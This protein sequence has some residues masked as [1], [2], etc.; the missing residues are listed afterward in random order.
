MASGGSIDLAPLRGRVTGTVL[1]PADAGWDEARRPWNLAI[2]QRPAAVLE[3]S[4]EGC[5]VAAAIEFARERAL[6]VCAQPTG[7]SATWDLAD[8]LLMRTGGLRGVEIDATARVARVEPGARWRDVQGAAGEHGLSGL[9]GTAPNVSVVGYAMGGGV[10]WLGRRYGVAANTIRAVELVTAAGEAVRVDR[11]SEPE[12][13]WALRGGGGNF[14]IVTAMELEL[15]PVERVYAGSLMWPIERAADVLHGWREWVRTLP[16]ETTSIATLLRVPPLPQ[17]PEPMRGRAFVV[18]GACHAGP[19]GEGEEVVRPL[20][21]LATPEMNSFAAMPPAGMG[22]IKNDPEDPTPG[23]SATGLTGD[24]DAEAVDRLLEAAGPDSGTPLLFAE[25]RHLGG[26]LARAP[27][28]HGVTGAVDA[29]FMFQALGVPMDPQ[30]APALREGLDRVASA[31]EPWSTGRR[32]L[33]FVEDRDLFP[34]AFSADDHRR[35]V[36]IKRRHDPDGVIQ[37]SHTL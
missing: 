26:A 2:D 16:D 7:H 21:E 36:E 22:A 10:S 32:L 37:T 35:L 1:G 12:L 27:E 18:V 6:G 28:G 13:F 34:S 5:E 4:G 20:I 33:N 30:A 17:V 29:S 9:P 11:E 23:V 15:T 14:G 24:L 3:L 19:E 31:L 25:L 8:V